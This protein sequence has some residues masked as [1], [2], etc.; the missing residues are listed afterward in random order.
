MFALCLPLPV[1]AKVPC[2]FL[3]QLD[4]DTPVWLPQER[5]ALSNKEALAALLL[6][7]RVQFLICSPEELSAVFSFK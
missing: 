1:A 7:A 6:T 2:I 3:S 5:Y 4:T